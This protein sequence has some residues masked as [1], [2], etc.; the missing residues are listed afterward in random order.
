MIF[1]FNEFVYEPIVGRDHDFNIFRESRIQAQVLNAFHWFQV[2]SEVYGDKGYTSM[3]IL[4]AAYRN[5]NNNLPF[6]RQQQNN[7]MKI[8]RGIA[9]EFPFNQ[10]LQSTCRPGIAVDWEIL[11]C[12]VHFSKCTYMFLF[13][14]RCFII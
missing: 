6:Y 11:C 4:H 12:S 14:C 9:A 5:I 10:I 7:R 8:V 3:R 13:K 2:F 1:F